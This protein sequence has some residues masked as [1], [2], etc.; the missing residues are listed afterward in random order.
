MTAEFIDSHCHLDFPELATDIDAHLERM[1][2]AGVSSAVCVA[3][4]LE[5]LPRIL[6]L[7]ER[8]PEVW[9]TV[10]V[11]PDYPESSEPS[12]DE[13]VRLAKHQKVI[14]IGETGLDYYRLTGDL[15]WQRERFRRHIQ[16]AVAINKPLIIHTRASAEDTLAII[17]SE[18]LPQQPGV[19]HCFTE[20]YEIARRAVDAGFMISFSGILSF[21]NAEPLREVARRLPLDCLLVETDAP[22]LAPVPYRGKMNQ[23]AYVRDVGVALAQAIGVSVERIAEI[24]TGNCKRLFGI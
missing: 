6:T 13:L 22:Y 3:V 9:A 17:Q 12:V 14:A 18:K 4:T 20:T 15:T 19:M 23:P 24:T 2:A 10:G 5:D 1:K 7:A 11:H 8:H 21:K 16:A